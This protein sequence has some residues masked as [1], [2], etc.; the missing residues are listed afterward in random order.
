[1]K[2]ATSRNIQ[3]RLKYLSAHFHEAVQEN[4]YAKALFE[5]KMDKTKYR[6]WLLRYYAFHASVEPKLLAFSPMF[7][8]HG[9]DIAE[10][11][12]VEK[13]KDDLCALAPQETFTCSKADTPKI[14]TFGE[15]V[16][17]LYVLEGSTMGG[18]IIKNEIIKQLGEDTPTTYFYPYGERKMEMWVRYLGSLEEISASLQKNEE[19]ILGACATFLYMDKAMR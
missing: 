9:I 13:L 12:R 14:D 18:E 17:A 1:M 2:D 16:G 19:I 4:G 8:Q 7:E 6:E 15:A 5:G 10:R 11:M 3:E